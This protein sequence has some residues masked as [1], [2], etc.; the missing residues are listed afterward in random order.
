MPLIACPDCGR[1]VSDQATA[2]PSCA[3]P[4]GGATLVE[5]TARKWKLIQAAGVVLMLA[6]LAWVFWPRH[7][8]TQADSTVGIAIL[9]AGIGATVVGRVGAWW[10]HG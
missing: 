3:R 8:P 7:T 6:G 10:K 2:C 1:Q 5:Q 4:L 9:G